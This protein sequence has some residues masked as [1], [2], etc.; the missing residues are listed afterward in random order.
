MPATDLSLWATVAGV[1]TANFAGYVYGYL[2]AEK[3]RRQRIS[4][5][6]VGRG[7]DA[8]AAGRSPRSRV[9]WEVQ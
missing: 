8:S 1:V 3:A 9:T 5:A 7:D 2:S 6:Q 4:D